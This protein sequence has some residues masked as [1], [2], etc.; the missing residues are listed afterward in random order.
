L[1]HGP[2]FG[3]Q[4]PEFLAEIDTSVSSNFS[5]KFMEISLNIQ[6]YLRN[7]ISWNYFWIFVISLTDWSWSP[8][9]WI[10]EKCTAQL[11]EK[12]SSDH[13]Q[14]FMM[15]CSEQCCNLLPNI[16]TK[17]SRS[18]QLNQVAEAAP[19]FQIG[20]DFTKAFQELGPLCGHDGHD[21]KFHWI[22]AW[23]FMKLFKI[24]L[25]FQEH[26]DLDNV[27]KTNSTKTSMMIWLSSLRIHV[28]MPICANTI[29]VKNMIESVCESTMFC[30]HHVAKIPH[31]RT[32]RETFSRWRVVH[33]AKLH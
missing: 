17:F 12:N 1:P 26:L 13:F 14:K 31:G 4:V 2:G 16:L 11:Y 28:R 21:G 24:V 18:S 29:L 10:S 32:G 7:L 6:Q 23:T 19:F 5:D 9:V 33:L 3:Y 27:E 30:F 25:F 15:T 20:P 22:S 8:L